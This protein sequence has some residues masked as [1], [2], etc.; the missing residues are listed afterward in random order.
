MNHI[1]FF[2]PGANK[3]AAFISASG[4]RMST[5]IAGGL[6]ENGVI[7]GN[8]YDK[9]GSRNPVV[10]WLMNGFDSSLHELLKRASPETIHEIGCGEGY[11][12]LRWNMEGF[13]AR[14][15][16][17]SRKVIDIARDNAIEKG[18]SPEIFTA[19][20]IYELSKNE[21]SADLVVC[22]EVLEHLEHP[23]QGLAALSRIARQHVILSVPR[24]PLWRALNMM[25]LK[26]LANLGNTPGHVQHWQKAKFIRLAGNYFRVVC[27]RTP[28]PWTMVLC[29]TLE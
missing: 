18:I 9:Y 15:T 13:A 5:K 29:K 8:T 10:R 12:V 14:G 6:N 2:F 16:D 21:D 26:Y 1:V 4:G 19:R 11:W 3:T 28:L 25:R 20:S 24:E 7:A 17:F 27:I 22:C 23:E